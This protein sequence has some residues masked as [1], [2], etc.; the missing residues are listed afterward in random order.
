MVDESRDVKVDFVQAALEEQHAQDVDL[1][2]LSK[3]NGAIEEKKRKRYQHQWCNFKQCNKE[4]KP[5]FVV[6]HHFKTQ[7]W[8]FSHPEKMMEQLKISKIFVLGNLEILFLLKFS[9]ILFLV[10]KSSYFK[11]LW[12]LILIRD[13]FWFRTLFLWSILTRTIKI[14][15]C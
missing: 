3:F 14:S 6:F 12:C 5:L 2:V 4:W 8:L 11:S 15:W 1:I 7:V 9:F 13:F 10:Q